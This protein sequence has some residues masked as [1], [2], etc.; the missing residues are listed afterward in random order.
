MSPS[1]DATATLEVPAPPAE[2]LAPSLDLAV[3]GHLPGARTSPPPKLPLLGRCW[4]SRAAPRV[5]SA[6]GPLLAR[7]RTGCPAP[8]WPTATV[9]FFLGA[10]TKKRRRTNC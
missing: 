6:T 4:C 10:M 5:L 1:G 7:V 3:R 2:G 9:V 8:D